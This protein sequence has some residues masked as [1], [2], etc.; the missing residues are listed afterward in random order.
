MGLED[1]ITALVERI[2]RVK[3]ALKT[4]EATKQSLI[5]PFIQAL[6]YD[7]FNPAEVTAELT[8]DFGIKQREKVDYAILSNG[9]PVIIIECKKV[10]DTLVADERV[11]QLFRYFNSTEARIGVLTNGIVYKFF[12]DLEE[13]NKMDRTPFLEIDLEHFH[14]GT[15][16]LLGQFAK[17]FDVAQTIEGADR[18]K[19]TNLMR[20]VLST[21]FSQPED[22]FVRWLANRVTTRRLTQPVL[23]EFRILARQSLHEFVNSH[24]SNALRSVQAGTLVREDDGS[25]EDGAPAEND[26]ESR[27]TETTVEELDAFA[28]VKS[29]AGDIVAPERIIIR[30]AQAYCAVNV[31]NR[32]KPICRFYFNGAQKRI[33]LF[34][35]TRASSGALIV[36]QHD[37]ESVDGIHAYAEQIRE[38]ARG[39]LES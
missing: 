33:G 3:D 11:S 26:A 16:K 1:G 8:A 29:I 10:E 25:P 13:P 7:I 21:Q 34:D 27:N 4:E 30:D 18:L 6:G 19:H 17:G 35:G 38:T 39:Y 24:I 32:R 9:K 12:T 37:I 14:P 5:L 28:I 15:V 31:D 2:P 22:D 23:E 36:T 20:E